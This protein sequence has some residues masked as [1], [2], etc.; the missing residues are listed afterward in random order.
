MQVLYKERPQPIQHITSQGRFSK[1]TVAA[2]AVGAEQKQHPAG[3]LHMQEPQPETQGQTHSA[4]LLRQLARLRDANRAKP[5]SNG[6][7]APADA[8]GNRRSTRKPEAWEVSMAP[9]VPRPAN[10]EESSPPVQAHEVRGSYPSLHRSSLGQA[11]VRT[12]KAQESSADSAPPE[13]QLVKEQRCVG[14]QL[15]QTELQGGKKGARLRELQ[16]EYPR[17]VLTAYGKCTE[18]LVVLL[19]QAMQSS[20]A[21]ARNIAWRARA[22]R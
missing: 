4:E 6:A 13:I 2:N 8:D 12:G 7:G 15:A 3:R 9:E 11:E 10:R 14:Q 5:S 18:N 17:P 19:L 22:V 20:G 21:A 1:D 16:T